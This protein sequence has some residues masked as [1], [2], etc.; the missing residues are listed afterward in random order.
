VSFYNIHEWWVD[1]NGGCRVL[2]HGRPQ[3]WQLVTQLRF[4]PG[5]LHPKYNCK[6][7]VAKPPFPMSYMYDTVSFGARGS[8]VG[9]SVLCYKSEGRSS[10]PDE[11]IGFFYWPNPSNRTTVLGST[12]PL[13]EMSTR[14]LPEGKGRPARKA[15][16]HTA[17]CEP[18]F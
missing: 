12:K 16:N 8:T 4:E 10:I 14:N 5:E 6:T 15:D 13:T 18:I 3:V 7:V 1:R 2:F 9:W 11:V 17:I